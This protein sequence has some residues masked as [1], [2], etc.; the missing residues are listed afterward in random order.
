[1]IS[2]IVTRDPVSDRN[3]RSACTFSCARLGFATLAFNSVSGIGRS[4]TGTLK[5]DG[6]VVS[7]QALEKSI[8]ILF[9]IDETFDIGSDTGAGVND[10]DYQIP[11]NFTGKIDKLIIAIDRPQLTPADVQKLKQGAMAAQ[12]A[13]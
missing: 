2:R 9:T 8:P 13:K 10:Q 12:D 11:F 6:K 1:M 3:R 4:G 5:V 7:T